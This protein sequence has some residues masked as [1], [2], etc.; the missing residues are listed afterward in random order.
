MRN[1]FIHELCNDEHIDQV[2]TR[3][4]FQCQPLGAVS[5]KTMLA[6]RRWFLQWSA[7]SSFSGAECFDIEKLIS[8]QQW[9]LYD[10]PYKS[11]GASQYLDRHIGWNHEIGIDFFERKAINIVKDP[12]WKHGNAGVRFKGKWYGKIGTDWKTAM[13]SS[14]MDTVPGHSQSGETSQ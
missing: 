3:A 7:R 8:P 9:Y 2:V 12:N 6:Q 4:R 10:F 13:R 5:S 11:H 1:L 14:L